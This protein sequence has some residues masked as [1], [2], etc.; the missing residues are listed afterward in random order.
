MGYL[1]CCLYANW[2]SYLLTYLPMV[3]W[4]EVGRPVRAAVGRY[5]FSAMLS[6]RRAQE[7]FEACILLRHESGFGQ[8]YSEVLEVP[9]YV[10]TIPT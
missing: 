6:G 10:P 1:L 3:G 4:I 9:T 8:E 2:P 7:S 5:L